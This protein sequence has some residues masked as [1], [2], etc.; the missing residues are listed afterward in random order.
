MGPCKV[1]KK[2][3]QGVCGA[4]ADVIVARNLLRSLAAGVAAHGARGRET[5]LALKAA[6]EGKLE[7][8]LAG[9]DKIL[10][11]ATQFGIAVDGRKLEDILASRKSVAEG[12]PTSQA[13]ARMARENDVDMPIVLAVDAVLNHGANL[14]ETI[15]ALLS[16]PFR[17]ERNC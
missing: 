6:A 16:R 15:T 9:K 12:V 8:P 1:T 5:M 7:I 10:K 2:S 14:S 11:S 17:A 4:N 3:P 13:A